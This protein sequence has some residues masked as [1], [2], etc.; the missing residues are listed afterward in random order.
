MSRLTLG[1]APDTCAPAAFQAAPG[2]VE[3]GADAPRPFQL[4]LEEFVE[5]LLVEWLEEL[6]DELPV[7]LFE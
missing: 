6:D 5:E 2:Q 1:P 7:E 3:R 4:L